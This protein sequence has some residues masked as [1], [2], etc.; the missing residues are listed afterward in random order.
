M[1]FSPSGTWIP[2][3]GLYTLALYLLENTLNFTSIHMQ[4]TG[5]GT[6]HRT[7]VNGTPTWFGTVGDV[8]SNKADIGH[9]TAQTFAR[10]E[11]VDPSF[12]IVEACLTFST[13]L[14][15]PF[16]SWRG[17]YQPLSREVWMGV[18]VSV[19]V[20]W[21]T[22]IVL[23][24][25]EYR[26]QRVW[27][28]SILLEY[29]FATLLEQDP[30]SLTRNP[31]SSHALRTF[32]IFWLMFTILVTTAYRSTLVT[33]LAFPNMEQPPETFEELQ[34]STYAIGLQYIK[35]AAYQ[36]LK[37][38]KNPTYAGIFKRMSLEE[39]DVAC[40]LKSVKSRYACIS[41]DSIAEFVKHRNLTD[42]YGRSPVLRSPSCT[43]GIVAGLVME[44]RAIFKTEIDQVFRW[45]VAGGILNKM[46]D[47]DVQF[48]RRERTA[49]LK[50][51]GMERDSVS[52]MVGEKG[53]KTLNL[54][55]F[56]GSFYLFIICI[57]VCIVTFG[58]E[59]VDCKNFG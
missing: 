19:M 6:G 33:F 9:A 44:K 43:F 8:L 36:L 11:V 13:G 35:G 26:H 14:P 15:I 16:Y 10:C 46:N 1:T 30:P 27:K 23:A 2:K 31:S 22:F 3:R 41:W 39:D 40:F 47:L 52:S 51:V 4:A 49:W 24:R 54:S 58:R 20:G 37:H 56:S 32:T 25:L 48:I 42:K 7:I 5:G 55:H 57:L 29:A 34:S 50:E 28:P 17:V 45:M 38:S 53:S 18:G 59:F 21:V 12:P